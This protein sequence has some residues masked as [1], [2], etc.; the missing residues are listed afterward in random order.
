MKKFKVSLLL[1][2]SAVIS[3]CSN[4]TTNHDNTANPIGTSQS[5]HSTQT[6]KVAQKANHQ[7][8]QFVEQFVDDFWAEMPDWA[9]DM[10]YRKYAHVLTVPDEHSRHKRL[11]FVQQQQQR[12]HA[13]PLAKLNHNQKTDYYLIDNLLK[14]QRWIITDAKTHQWD[15]VEYNVARGFAAI[16][17]DNYAPLDQRLL[18]FLKRTENVPA[19][20]QAAKANITTPTMEHTELAILQNQGALGLFSDQLLTKVNNSGLTAAQKSLF[21]QR[22][23]SAKTA[24][25]GYIDFLQQLKQQLIDNGNARSFRLGE[26]LYEQKFAMDIQSQYSAKQVYQKA[27]N[28]L[29][30][31]SQK[32]SQLTTQLWPKYFP[33]TAQPTNASSATAKLIKHLSVKHVKRE[34]FVDEIRQQIPA[35]EAFIRQKDLL[36][37]SPDKPLIVRETPAYMRGIAGASISAPGPYDQAG[38]TYYNVTPLDNMSEQQA[39]SYLSE[40]NHWMLQILNIHEAIPGHYTQLVYA[41][42]SPSLIKAILGNGAMVEGW[43]VYTERMM[44][45]QGY[46]DFEPELWLMYYKWNMRVISNTILDYAVHVGGMTKA[47]GLDLLMNKVFQEKAEAEGKWRRVTL[48]QVQLTSYYAGYREIYDFREE[49]KAK[50]GKDFDLK[51]FHEAFLSYGRAPVKYI[52]ALMRQ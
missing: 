5:S 16:I 50:A 43:A 36:T 1:L 49:M 46:G 20:Y 17:N 6:E 7:F 26:T 24:I 8:S 30:Q 27:L 4:Q 45:E 10:G 47:Q 51:G 14:K 42:Q 44:L 31:V 29:E 19:Y 23:D 13:I 21:K 40:Y 15:P 9:M 11:A 41:N 22:V 32:I 34:D 48:S 39:L 25:N 38:N 52:K 28:D 18:S 35:L 33:D 3:S 12:L 2:I 37:L